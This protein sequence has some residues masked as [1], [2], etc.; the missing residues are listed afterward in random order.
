MD[1][2]KPMPVVID[3]KRH[4]AL[5]VK[6]QDKEYLLQFVIEDGI[7]AFYVEDTVVAATDGETIDYR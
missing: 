6:W 4:A 2:D 3:V 5:L 7:L 1:K